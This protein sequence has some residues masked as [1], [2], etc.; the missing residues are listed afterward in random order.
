MNAPRKPVLGEFADIVTTQGMRDWQPFLSL[1]DVHVDDAEALI[2]LGGAAAT[3]LVRA[4]LAKDLRGSESGSSVINSALRIMSGQRPPLHLLHVFAA[5]A[6]AQSILLPA[7]RVQLASMLQALATIT[8]DDQ[9][10]V[11]RL[12]A[13][14]VPAGGTGARL[15]EIGLAEKGRPTRIGKAFASALA[16]VQ[17]LA[18]ELDELRRQR[19]AAG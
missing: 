1:T 8:A 18:P 5:A 11:L 19:Q 4:R 7:E 9:P 15:A 14:Q 6:A 17:Q 10:E 12:A 3:E 2:V 16:V 13:D